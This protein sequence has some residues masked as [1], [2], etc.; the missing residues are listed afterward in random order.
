M[1]RLAAVILLLLTLPVRANLGENVAELTKRYGKFYNFTE[2]NAKTP[3]GTI[4]FIAGPYEMI[5]FLYQG[6]EVGAR[7]SKRDK[8]AFNPDEIKTI[9]RRFQS[10]I[11]A[12]EHASLQINFGALDFAEAQKS[13]RLFGREIIPAFA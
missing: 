11:G 5:V 4:A 8:S 1:F 13:M 6:V 10:E 12:F 2:A 9:I 3:F 7:V